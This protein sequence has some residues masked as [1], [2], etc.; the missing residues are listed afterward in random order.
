L[1]PLLHVDQKADRLFIFSPLFGYQQEDG[2]RTWA[3]LPLLLGQSTYAHGSTTIAGP[4]YAVRRNKVWYGGLAPLL[5]IKNAPDQTRVTLLPL[6]HVDQQADRL[7]ILSPLFGY[8]RQDGD[9]T[10]AVPP[11]FLGQNTFAGGSIT[12]AGPIYA[13]RRDKVWYGG[14]APLLFIKNAP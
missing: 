6:L 9:S 3:V 14:L 2:D 5:F 1:L 12:V 13:V 8:H 11:L 7:L 4:V 10:W